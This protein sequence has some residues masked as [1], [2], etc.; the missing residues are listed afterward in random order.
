VRPFRPAEPPVESEVEEV[1]PDFDPD[2]KEYEKSF[3]SEMAEYDKKRRQSYVERVH[4]VARVSP[5]ARGAMVESGGVLGRLRHPVQGRALDEV[6]TAQATADAG[7][8]F[9]PRFQCCH[10]PKVL[11]ALVDIEGGNHIWLGAVRRVL[12]DWGRLGVGLDIFEFRFAPRQL[13]TAANGRRRSLQYVLS[14]YPDAPVLLIAR[15]IDRDPGDLMQPD[16]LE[17]LTR[18]RTCAW[19]DPSPEPL[20]SSRARQVRVFEQSGLT[21]FLLNDRSL[22]ALAHY[23]VTDGQSVERST[24]SQWLDPSEEVLQPTLKRWTTAAL[25]VP[26]ASWDDI[27]MVRAHEALREHFPHRAHASVLLR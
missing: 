6:Q 26:E 14:Q 8:A 20:S 5:V 18:S 23:I 10:R 24:T 22:V 13:T 15:R 11:L 17:M 7:G 3:E 27:E 2:A 4:D 16:W 19:L 25:L 12:L 21:R 9:R 1:P